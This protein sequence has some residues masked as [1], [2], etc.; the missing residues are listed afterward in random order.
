MSCCVVFGAV[1]AAKLPVV[2]RRPAGRHCWGGAESGISYCLV[3]VLSRH[4]QCAP[5]SEASGETTVCYSSR[6]TSKVKLPLSPPSAC[7]PYTRPL[8]PPRPLPSS[9]LHTLAP[10]TTRPSCP[11]SDA[12]LCNPPIPS[13]LTRTTVHSP[14]TSP[15]WR[16]PFNTPSHEACLGTPRGAMEEDERDPSVASGSDFYSEPNTPATTHQRASTP[17]KRKAEDSDAGPEKKRKLEPMSSSLNPSSSPLLP[18]IG[19]PPEIWQNVFLSCSPATLGR[20][21]QVSKSFR[22]YLLDVQVPSQG[23]LPPS[24]GTRPLNVVTSESI[25]MA[26]RKDHATRPP[27][28]PE[29]VSE[30]DLWPFIM[31][32]ECHFC[33]KSPESAPGEKPWEKG[34]GQNGVRIIWPFWVRACGPCLQERCEKVCDDHKPYAI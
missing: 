16:Q 11:D 31:G 32:K 12:L 3:R 26:A 10:Y 8:P 27:R 2:G 4:F 1:L 18:C 5:K 19:L 22:S 7:S 20:L 34:P 25:W 29:G 17:A 33:K 28:P 14:R 15:P 30:V 23:I 24:H 6:A 9:S 21:L 13:P